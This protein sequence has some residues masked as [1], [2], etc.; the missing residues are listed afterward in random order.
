M[1]WWAAGLLTLVVASP[2]EAAYFDGN[3]LYTAC[4]T[5]QGT[6]NYFQEQSRCLAYIE[7]ISDGLEYG[8]VTQ[9]SSIRACV[10]AGVTGGQIMD[11]VIRYLW[12]H[13]EIRHLLASQLVT[14]ALIESFPCR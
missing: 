8:R 7:G 14:S 3:Q 11:V 2:A 12:Q 4:T 13:S 10:P 9:K 5:Q 6:Y 1:K